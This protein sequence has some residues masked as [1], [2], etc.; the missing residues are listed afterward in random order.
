MSV[1]RLPALMTLLLFAGRAAAAEV[2]FAK[3]IKPILEQTCLKCHGPEK[4]K[5]DLR[6]DTQEGLRKGS[7][8]GEVI[9]PGKADESVLFDLITADKDDPMRMPQETDP[10]TEQ[11]IN[12]I[13]D[14]INEGAKWPEGLVLKAP[15]VAASP[16]PPVDPGLPISDAEKAAVGKVQ[17]IGALAL[18]LAQNTNL[19]RVDFSLQGREVK[20]EDLACLKDMPNLVELSLGSTK[21]TDAGLVHLRETKTLQRLR[22]EKTAVTDA[23]LENLKGLEK[24]TYLN[25]YGTAVTDAGLE[26][27]KGLKNLKKLYLWQTKVTEEGAKK[28]AEAVPGIM[29]NRGIEAEPKPPEEKKEEPKKEEPKKE[30]AKQ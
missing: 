26:H 10:L 12:L 2:D 29:I 13:R 7:K 25:L 22:L 27:L 21:V 5:G 14:W 11:Q 1:R 3:D 6:L 19:L 8:T 24:L 23:G 20:D 9:V 15:A 17:Q 4:P 28:L 16:I 18:R 30:E